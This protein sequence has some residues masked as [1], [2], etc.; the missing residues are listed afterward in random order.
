MTVTADYPQI[1][2]RIL[3]IGVGHPL[4][5]DDGA[6]AAVVRNLRQY[7]REHPACAQLPV[8]L[9]EANGDLMD[10]LEGG[11]NYSKVI[12]VDAVVTGK[13]PGTLHRWDVTARPLPACLRA[14]STHGFDLAGA[15][16]LNRA[17][18]GLPPSL[19][20]YGIEA[21]Q[22]E[23]GAGLSPAVKASARTILAPLLEE[24]GHTLVP[25]GV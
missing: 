20:I 5:G 18:N 1:E 24:L 16:E 22:F 14:C 15:I 2:N 7:F 25:A 23:T 8:E 19:I 6:G 13:P 10:M 21:S 3:V 11:L 9:A 4:R 12:L 17:L